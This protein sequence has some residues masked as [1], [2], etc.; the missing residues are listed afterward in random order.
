MENNIDKPKETNLV[1]TFWIIGWNITFLSIAILMFNTK[2]KNIII[3]IIGLF[4]L[5]LGIIIFILR[6]IL[7]ISLL[8]KVIKKVS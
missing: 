1:S 6:K 5:L 7:Q 4:F 8:K 2:L 3:T